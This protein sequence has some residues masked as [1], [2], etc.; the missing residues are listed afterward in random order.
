MVKKFIAGLIIG[1]LILGLVFG[2]V[3]FAFNT[4]IMMGEIGKVEEYKLVKGEKIDKKFTYNKYHYVLT[5][6]KVD[7]KDYKSNNFLIKYNGK[8]Y[9]LD[10][11]TDCDMSSYVKDNFIYAHCIGYTGNIV[12]FKFYGT[13]VFNEVIEFN[14]DKTP[15]ISQRHIEVDKVTDKYIYLKSNV[16]KDDNIK[17]GNKVK[18]SF[19]N[20]NKCVYVK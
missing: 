7:G 20:G 8:Y 3:Y 16:K 14:Y 13:R 19:E 5:S 17:E 18:C 12:K 10:S 11:F 6:F 2:L 15:N 4:V 1:L 9:Y